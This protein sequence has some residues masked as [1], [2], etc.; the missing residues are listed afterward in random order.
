MKTFIHEYGLSLFCIIC[1]IFLICTG[2]PVSAQIKEGIG[3]A[4]T[5]ASNKVT[6]DDGLLANGSSA[7]ESSI[8]EMNVMN[9]KYEFKYYTSIDKA[10]TDANN[11][12]TENADATKENGVV[13]V[14]INNTV[15]TAQI[16]LMKDTQM[17][18]TIKYTSNV[19]F[20]LN[21]KTLGVE[22][23]TSIQYL[24]DFRI[25]DGTVHFVGSLRGITGAIS[26]S[27]QASGAFL[28]DNVKFINNITNGRTLNLGGSYSKDIKITNCIFN[29]MNM[30][31]IYAAPTN[32]K[33]EISNCNIANTC[34]TQS[35][36]MFV[37][38]KEVIVKGNTINTQSMG[39]YSANGNNV[40]LEENTI[41][42]KTYGLY[43]LNSTANVNSGKFYVKNEGQTI[44]IFSNGSK[45][46]VND[47]YIETNSGNAS[48]LSIGLY[49]SKS[50]IG[51]VNNINTDIKGKYGNYGASVIDSSQLYV[52]GGK[53]IALPW[54]KGGDADSN[55][56]GIANSGKT[57][58]DENKNP[59]IVKGGN[60]GLHIAPGSNTV[61]NGGS[62]A[63]PNHGGAYVACG[64]SGHFEINGGTFYNNRNEYDETLVKDIRPFGGMY[65]GSQQASEKWSVNIKNAKIINEC[66]EQG[67]VQKSND[68]YIP[69]T[70]NLYNTE[71]SGKTY[72]IV[73]QNNASVGT[74]EAYINLYEGTVLVHNTQNDNYGNTVGKKYIVDH[75]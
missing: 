52:H 45:V 72:D 61:V 48:N 63:S 65:I 55:G 19:L 50:S 32:A 30:H 26:Q 36:A 39:V 11:M 15:K 16:M 18:S 71:I 14:G 47:G 21:G 58:I 41:E 64:S 70:I 28:A 38:G 13:A 42:C 54:Y 2:S 25:K 6:S 10:S 51:T 73:N 37:G 5:T 22:N 53:F 75:R 57:V 34:T 49:L 3:T 24:K 59:V 20:N 31:P 1:I 33:V 74:Y 35:S 4:V 67:L 43:L 44:G 17:K 40:T 23:G 29:V 66:G 68:G 7:I 60:C 27:E 46:T 56:A 9:A 12:T 62:F 69:A 8:R